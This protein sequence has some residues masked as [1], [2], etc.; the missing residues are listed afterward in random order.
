[1]ERTIRRDEIIPFRWIGMNRHQ[2]EKNQLAS[3]ITSLE[4][5]KDWRILNCDH[6]KHRA[7]MIAQGARPWHGT[8]AHVIAQGARNESVWYLPYGVG[9]YCRILELHWW[10]VS[11]NIVFSLQKLE[12]PECSKMQ[13]S[14]WQ[15]M[16]SYF[17]IYF[18]TLENLWGDL[19]KYF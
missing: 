10:F 5:E 16:D 6:N 18:I 8:R 9:H 1:M 3:K 15:L 11:A 4:K 7:D 19:E 12:G 14:K 2:K 13:W 17:T